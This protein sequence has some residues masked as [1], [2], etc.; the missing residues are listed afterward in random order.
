MNNG[1]IDKDELTSSCNSIWLMFSEAL[2][3]LFSSS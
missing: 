1:L 2:F 3:N